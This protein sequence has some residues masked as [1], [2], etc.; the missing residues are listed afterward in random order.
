MA[1]FVVDSIRRDSN[2][3]ER[4]EEVC[5]RS[6]FLKELHNSQALAHCHPE[7]FPRFKKPQVHSKILFPEPKEEER[8]EQCVTGGSRWWE[9]RW[10]A[11]CHECG[12]FAKV[13]AI[14][15]GCMVAPRACKCSLDAGD[16]LLCDDCNRR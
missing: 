10:E 4:F 12:Y 6:G 9:A 14:C 2:T 11:N 5:G 13:Q 8:S 1:D 7:K 3:C 15:S 16:L